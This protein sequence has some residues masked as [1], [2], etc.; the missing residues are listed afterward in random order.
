LMVGPVPANPFRRS[1]I[2]DAGDR[3]YQGTFTWFPT[4][5]SFDDR[6]TLKNDTLPEVDIARRDER[7]QGILV[8]SRFPAWEVREVEDG[9][10]VNL[11]D[12][13]F[14]GIGRGGFTAT[15]LVHR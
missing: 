6:G 1:I 11:R 15:V 3:Y 9:V 13:R 7:I 12:M 8:W 10:E 4:R 14:R 5:V 2:V